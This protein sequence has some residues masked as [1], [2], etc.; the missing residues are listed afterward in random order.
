MI[1]IWVINYIMN[2]TNCNTV[3]LQCLQSWQ[4]MTNNVKLSLNS[5]GDTTPRF[6]INV[7]QI[8]I[9]HTKYH[10]WYSMW[11][12]SLLCVFKYTFHLQMWTHSLMIT[13][14]MTSCTISHKSWHQITCAVNANWLARDWWSTLWYV[15]LMWSPFLMGHLYLYLH[16]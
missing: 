14:A 16:N 15:G 5:V 2:Y 9:D 6:T 1:V 13:S 3:N 12:I 7:E 8:R 10:I 4:G 11:S